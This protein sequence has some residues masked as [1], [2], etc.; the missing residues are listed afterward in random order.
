MLLPREEKDLFFFIYFRLLIYV[1]NE[2]GM[3]R[4]NS[5]NELKDLGIWR[6]KE[7]RD[8]LYDD[9][10]LFGGFIE[11]NPFN[12]GEEMLEIVKLWQ[13]HFIRGRFIILKY[14][15]RYAVFLDPFDPPRAYGVLALTDPFNVF[16]PYLPVLVETVLLPF[17]GKIV[18]DGLVEDLNVY[19]GPGIRK[20]LNLL[21]RR[22]RSLYGLITR[23]PFEKKNS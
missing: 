12:L 9:P 22:A 19:F 18:Y 17:R 23:L 15:K 7:I 6:I 14:L 1:S 20:D 13:R 10:S 16:F 11:E 4:V 8:K 5:V 3:Y 21:Y 2:L